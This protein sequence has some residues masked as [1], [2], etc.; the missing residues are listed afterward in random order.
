MTTKDL[1][2]VL[3]NAP[4]QPQVAP[5]NFPGDGAAYRRDQIR[6]HA[7]LLDE[8]NWQLEFHRRWLA[9]R[10]LL[11]FHPSP[12]VVHH[13]P[14]WLIAEMRLQY[15]YGPAYGSTVVLRHGHSRMRHIL[16]APS[17]PVV[18]TSRIAR[19]MVPVRGRGGR[20]P[21]RGG[22]AAPRSDGCSARNST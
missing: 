11:R 17:L 4:R 14:V 5:Q 22:P 3:A 13:G 12:L 6:A 9:S 19:R 15:R 7:D 18:L 2:V 21:A 16:L 10:K 8:R 1:S 20:P